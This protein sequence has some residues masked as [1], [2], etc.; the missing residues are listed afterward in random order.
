MK[1]IALAALLALFG[2]VPGMALGTPVQ[3]HELVMESPEMDPALVEAI[4]RAAAHEIGGSY[5]ELHSGYLAGEVTIEKVTQGYR[6]V[7][8][9]G[10]AIGVIEESL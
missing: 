5:E 4:L 1:K 8:G 7:T 9:S 2:A 3:Q 6:V 10:A